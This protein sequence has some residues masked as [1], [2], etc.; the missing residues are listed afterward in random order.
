MGQRLTTVQALNRAMRIPD[1]CSARVSFCESYFLANTINQCERVFLP[2]RPQCT[3]MPSH[4]NRKSEKLK[5]L[6]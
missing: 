4:G 1:R 2:Y 5:H 6:L 3:L